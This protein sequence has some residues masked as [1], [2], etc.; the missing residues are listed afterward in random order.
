LIVIIY[1]NQPFTIA[2]EHS[3]CNV[4][5]AHG[6]IIVVGLIIATK[7]EYVSQGKVE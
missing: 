2:V 6:T 7:H 4:P 5:R 3:F 1:E